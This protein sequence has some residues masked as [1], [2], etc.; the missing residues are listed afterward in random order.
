LD[1]ITHPEQEIVPK[2]VNENKVA[3]FLVDRWISVNY[4]SDYKDVLKI[5]QDKLLEF[6]NA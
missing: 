3:V 4:A 6:L 5:G 1:K 2:L